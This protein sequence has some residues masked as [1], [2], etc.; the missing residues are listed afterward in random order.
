MEEKGLL[1]AQF[2]EAIEINRSSLT[3][4]FS[5]RNQPSLE[6]ARKILKAFPDISTEWLIMGS[7]N[8]YT[9]EKKMKDPPSIRTLDLFENIPDESLSVPQTGKA[10][11]NNSVNEPV[12]RRESFYNASKGLPGEEIPLPLYSEKSSR[13][14]SPSSLRPKITDKKIEKIVF[15]YTDKTFESFFPS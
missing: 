5:G 12:P 4:I 8:M 3:H 10:A 1:P 15:F 9:A 7:G 2:A 6:L 13:A 11:E 14:T